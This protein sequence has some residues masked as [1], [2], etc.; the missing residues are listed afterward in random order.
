[1]HDGEMNCPNIWP[2]LDG[3]LASG[4]VLCHVMPALNLNRGISENSTRLDLWLSFPAAVAPAQ[5]GSRHAASFFRIITQTNDDT[6][7]DRQFVPQQKQK[8]N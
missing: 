2:S 1:M 3:W 4:V 7:D 6:N 5:N 8:Q